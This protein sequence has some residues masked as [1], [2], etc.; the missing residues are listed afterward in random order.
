MLSSEVILISKEILYIVA[1]HK[2][3]HGVTWINDSKAT[4]VE[5]T[6]T[7]LMG[8]RKQN[9]VILLGGLAKVVVFLQAKFFVYFY[10]VV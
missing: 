8:L 3:T 5:A 9:S 10:M 7:A 4:N 1:V 6:Y 2:D